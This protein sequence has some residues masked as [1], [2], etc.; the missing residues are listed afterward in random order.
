MVS[1]HSLSE[2]ETHP[3]VSNLKLRLEEKCF[4]IESKELE[5]LSPVIGNCR[6]SYQPEPEVSCF[7]PCL[8]LNVNFRMIVKMYD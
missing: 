7:I 8:F 4:E 2:L 3:Y 6:M 1:E 5:S